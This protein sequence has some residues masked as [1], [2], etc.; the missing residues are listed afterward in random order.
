MEWED[1]QQHTVVDG[2]V[3]MLETGWQSFT[4]GAKVTC[5]L[6]EGNYPATIVCAGNY[7]QR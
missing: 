7:V 1:G 6:K 2:K 4:L 5:H 3:A